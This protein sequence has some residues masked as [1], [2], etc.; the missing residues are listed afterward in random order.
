MT[1][2][3]SSVNVELKRD[4]GRTIVD[5][6]CWAFVRD[7]H[8]YRYP[9]KYAQYWRYCRANVPVFN[10]R[11]GEWTDFLT[12]K[13]ELDTKFS[14]ERKAGWLA[15]DMN[16]IFKYLGNQDGLFAPSELRAY[17]TEHALGD[18]E[19]PVDYRDEKRGQ[20]TVDELMPDEQ[21]W[22]KMVTGK[23]RVRMNPAKLFAWLEPQI[24]PEWPV[25]P[26]KPEL[27]ILLP[28]FEE[29]RPFELMGGVIVRG[30]LGN[31]DLPP[32]GS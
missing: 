31:L 21:A 24:E 22:Q 13:M 11:A 20:I 1:E 5:A 4:V 32:S 10:E 25:L 28:G 7:I 27:P 17:V 15:D 14:F 8:L 18:V 16:Y 9:A 19:N 2:A 12:N 26:P 29:F 6:K 23:S 3:L 30:A